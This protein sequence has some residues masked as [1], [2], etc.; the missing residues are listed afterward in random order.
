MCNTRSMTTT[1]QARITR[2]Y[3]YLS[4]RTQVNSDDV[5]DDYGNGCELRVEDLRAVLA[6]LRA[7]KSE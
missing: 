5:I 4:Q 2:V 1:E 6:A 7:A 3:T